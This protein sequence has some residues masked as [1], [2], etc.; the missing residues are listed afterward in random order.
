LRVLTHLQ[1]SKN[2]SVR[3]RNTS[4]YMRKHA[5]RIEMGKHAQHIEKGEHA[6][7]IEM[8]KHARDASRTECIYR[9]VA[10]TNAKI[11]GRKRIMT[12]P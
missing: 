5:Q 7:C 2:A 11:V 10:G 1:Y 9:Q 4:R 12:A 3:R 6:R 8:G